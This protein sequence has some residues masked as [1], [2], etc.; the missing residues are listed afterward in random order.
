MRLPLLLTVAVYSSAMVAL[1]CGDS[2]PSLTDH[3]K[4]ASPGSSLSGGSGSSSGTSNGS[5]TA[6]GSPSGMGSSSGL[7]SSGGSSG[8]DGG[9]DSGSSGGIPVD[10]GFPG[11]GGLP[12]SAGFPGDG[13]F[14]GRPGFPGDGGFPGRPGFPGGA[15]FPGD[16]GIPT[17]PGDGG[18]FPGRPGFPGG[19]GF[20]GGP[21]VCAAPDT[22]IATPSGER[23]IASLHVG[24]LVY[25]VDRGSVRVVP[26]LEAT[27]REVH[28]HHVMQVTLT[29][30]VRLEISAPHPTA[31]GRVFGQ[32]RAGDWLDGV[33]VVSAQPVPYPYSFTYDILPD[34]DTGT[35]LAGGA[36]IGT[37]LARPSHD[38]ASV[39][40]PTGSARTSADAPGVN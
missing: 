20:P 10:A 34:S 27:R 15:G 7:G 13:G 39:G 38:E 21:G 12:G 28:N 5:S 2:L 32:L 14:P 11:D 6:S 8:D 18:G 23:P 17:F 33:G 29:N 37:T 25:S 30:G 4:D 40:P 19:A 9:T 1:G 24:D 3:G 36:L 16:G 26:I 22:P 35:Y 31:D